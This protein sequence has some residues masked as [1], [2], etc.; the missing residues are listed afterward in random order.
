MLE[1][2]VEKTT[3]Y[4]AAMAFGYALLADRNSVYKRKEIKANVSQLF[5]RHKISQH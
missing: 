2:R 3:K 5:K 1:F 4:D